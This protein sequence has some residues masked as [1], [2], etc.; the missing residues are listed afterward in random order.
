M[1]SR[2]S[3]GG[4]QAVTSVTSV[5]RSA[6]PGGISTEVYIGYIGYKVG[7]TWWNL[8]GAELAKRSERVGVHADDR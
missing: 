6:P 3:L 7:A 2:V 4:E 5:T 8:D 1:L